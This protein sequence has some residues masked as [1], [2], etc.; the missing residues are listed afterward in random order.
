[1][2]ITG[3]VVSLIG[4]IIMIAIGFIKK[5]KSILLAQTGQFAVQGLGHLLLGAYSAVLCC[6]ISILRIG[7]FTRF[8]KVPAWLKLSF[9]AFQT[10]LTYLLGAH[11]FF[12]WVP[13]LS[14]ILY[15]WY[16]DTEDAILFKLVN[17]AGLML[18]VFHDFHY[19]NYAS[20]TFDLLTV[21][22]TIS[23]M[24]MV[25]KDRRKKAS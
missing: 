11:T 5:K 24:I 10:V 4:C 12:D 19:R 20:V 6:G 13:V 14:M 15:T 23:G 16:F 1:M 25:A 9:L 21:V 8:K 3:N 18:W 7:V 22:S 17:L 2:L